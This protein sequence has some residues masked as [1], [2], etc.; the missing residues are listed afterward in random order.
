MYRFL[1]S[2]F[3]KPIANFLIAFWYI[4]LLVYSGYLML[5]I[6]QNGLFRYIGW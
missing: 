2:Y 4:F 6:P 5:Q 1:I 3:P